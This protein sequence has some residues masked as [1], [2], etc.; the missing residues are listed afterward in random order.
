MALKE[1]VLA[2]S[3]E[4]IIDRLDEARTTALLPRDTSSADFEDIDVNKDVTGNTEEIEEAFFELESRIDE[5]TQ[6]MEEEIDNLRTVLENLE[7]DL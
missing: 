2:K 5:L 1:E 6:V 7:E 3:L 4:G